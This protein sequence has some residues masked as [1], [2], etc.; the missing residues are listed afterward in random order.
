METAEKKEYAKN[1]PK[2]MGE[3][4]ETVGIELCLPV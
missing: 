3:T 2:F 1:G 4:P